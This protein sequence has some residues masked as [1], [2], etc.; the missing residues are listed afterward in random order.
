MFRLTKRNFLHQ[1]KKTGNE[2][3]VCCDINFAVLHICVEWRFLLKA[4][5]LKPLFEK[6]SPTRATAIKGPCVAPA[7]GDV[8]DFGTTM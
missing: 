2:R 6:L 3:C 8:T 5:E 7:P 4:E 1:I